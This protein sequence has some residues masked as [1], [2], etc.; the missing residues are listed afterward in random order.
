MKGRG[1]KKFLFP[2]AEKHEANPITDYTR[3]LVC[4]IIF[5]K[6]GNIILEARRCPTSMGIY[7]PYFSENVVFR[8]SEVITC[9]TFEHQLVLKFNNF[10]AFSEKK[11]FIVGDFLHSPATSAGI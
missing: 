5:C 11:D 3:A 10:C 1:D 7:S 9:I 2:D 8:R 6:Y 4:F